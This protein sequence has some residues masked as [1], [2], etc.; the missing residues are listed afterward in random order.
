MILGRTG[1]VISDDFSVTDQNN[2]LVANIDSTAFTVHLFNN[3]GNE[4]SG[5]IPVTISQMGHGHYRAQFTPN[6]IGL[7]MLAVYHATYFP[8]GKTNNTQIFA[9]DFDSISVVLT[10]ILGLTQENFY[11]DNTTYDPANNL[12]ASRIRIYSNAAS[13]GTAN[14]VIATYNMT[15]SYTDNKIDSYSVIK[16]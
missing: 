4:V 7:W 2:D 13:V 6:A 11:I 8:W 12:I 9:N 16:T 14:N 10:R 3:I 15:A 1:V 5:S